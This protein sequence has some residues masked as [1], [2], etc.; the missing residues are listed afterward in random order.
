M[1]P[2]DYVI[3]FD[4]G[5]TTTTGSPNETIETIS[6]PLTVFGD[7]DHDGIPD[8][9]DNCPDTAN[10][11]QEDRD[12]DG[13]GDVCDPHPN[14]RDNDGVEDDV[15]NCPDH[16]NPDQLDS[17]GDWLGDAC[18][19][20]PFDRDN[21]GVD[22][23]VD[24]CPDHFNPAQQDTDG[25]GIGDA[26]EKDLDNDG[27]PN[28]RDNCPLTPNPDQRDSDLRPDRL[29]DACDP[30]DTDGDGIPDIEDNCPSKPNPDQA[31]AN[32][33]GVGD[34]CDEDN[35]TDMDGI[36]DFRDNC[37]NVF[38]PSQ[39]DSDHDGLGDACETDDSDGDGVRDPLD[40]CPISFNPGQL[41]E[42]GDGIG[43]NCDLDHDPDHDGIPD[44]A[45][46][47]DFTVNPGQ[48]DT[49]GNGIGDACDRFSD[50]DGDGFSDSEEI[51]MGTNPGEFQFTAP[52]INTYH[53]GEPTGPANAATSGSRIAV[54]IPV[55]ATVNSVAVTATDPKGNIT[56][57]D[58]LIPHSPVIFSF[59]PNSVGAWRITSKLYSGATLLT[60]Y[61]RYLAVVQKPPRLAIE[62]TND[63]AQILWPLS[64]ASF[65]L[66]ETTDLVSPPAAGSWTQ[67][68]LPYQTNATHVF[69]TLQPS[70]VTKF[71]RL[72]KP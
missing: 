56:L 1:P 67:L 3:H 18:D 69:V 45:D 34:V 55:G 43:D 35:D 47:C 32:G 12:H 15:D 36:P 53:D 52:G 25:D 50:S 5:L 29:G 41:D 57:Q 10:P 61:N 4:Y 64:I 20:Y 21:D 71:Y 13:L 8:Q 48:Q 9:T 60:T 37:P 27:I 11:G 40:N 16:Y 38:N 19:P 49:N 14:D 26:C 17:D 2:G 7:R 33:N 6:I 39:E 63:N 68:P 62:F 66:D 51:Q 59:T 46:N 24:N 44:M 23:N 22:D 30:P 54:A 28:S 58:T 72:R 65:V 70:S 42:D 31:D